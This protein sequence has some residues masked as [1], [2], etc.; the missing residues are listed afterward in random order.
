MEVEGFAVGGLLR[1]AELAVAR[2]AEVLPGPIDGPGVGPEDPP[3]VE[4]LPPDEA[5]GD[6][7]G[8]FREGAW[9]ERLTWQSEAATNGFAV[10]NCFS[11]A[12]LRASN[13]DTGVSFYYQYKT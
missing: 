2:A 9:L 7:G 12:S 1:E 3:R 4:G 8:E 11:F 10:A 13:R 5:L 6:V